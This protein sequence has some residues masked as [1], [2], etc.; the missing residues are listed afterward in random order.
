MLTLIT[1]IVVMLFMSVSLSS[2]DNAINQGG[3]K[4]TLKVVMVDAPGNYEEVWVHIVRVEVNNDQ[5]EDSGWIVISEPDESY[6]LLELVNGAN[7]VLGE[8]EL[9]EGTYRQIRLILGEDNYVV[10][11]GQNYPMKTPSAQQTG[12]KLNVDAEIE[13]GFT[14]TLLL[15]FDAQRSVVKRGAT[16]TYL[17]KPVIRAVNSA[18]TG[19]ITGRVD[20][21]E[22]GAWVYAIAGSD[23]ASTTKTVETGHFTLVG[24]VDGFYT[25]SIEPI[26]EDYD[27]VQLEEVEVK[28]G[29]VTDLNVI[30]LTPG[31]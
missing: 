7:V 30:E 4:G 9:D 21:A 17:L 2:C 24:L 8:A 23:T 20:P 28:A 1:G 15:D 19:N 10:I 27:P 18:L 12:L 14:Y 25:V 5:D 3:D 31:E 13:A 26:D 16:G 11:G 29:Q 22:P 6:D